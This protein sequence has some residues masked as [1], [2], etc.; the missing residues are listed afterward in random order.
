VA[1][2]RFRAVYCDLDGT[3]LDPE[4]RITPRTL[5]ALSALRPL[6]VRTGIASGRTFRSAQP[7]LSLSGV[8]APAILF[9]GARVQSLDGS[10][11]RETRL[12]AAAARG[13]ITLARREGVFVN[14][15]HGDRV[16]IEERN[17]VSAASAEKDG[18]VQELVADLAALVDES[19]P[20]KLMM[21]ASPQRLDEFE[22]GARAQLT[23]HGIDADLVRSEPE[24]L[25]ALA[26]GVSKGAALPVAAE[27]LGVPLAEMVAFGDQL[28]DIELLQAAG[29]GVAMGN[30]HPELQ[31]LAERVC[32]SNAEDGIAATL[33]ELF[34]L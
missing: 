13:L 16:S 14:C 26:P 23:K 10:V 33:E 24:Y 30:A 11:H 8:D 3:L 29:L 28:N 25:E 31:R 5:A 34:G 7:Y 1:P 19:A 9:Q 22:R 21:I 12:A 27:L 15:Y 18:V 32:A 2:P 17:T 6:G 20:V 4:R